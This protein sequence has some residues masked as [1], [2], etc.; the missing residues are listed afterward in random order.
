MKFILSAIGTST[1]VFLWASCAASERSRWPSRSVGHSVVP[2]L[3]GNA[4]FWPT[5]FPSVSSTKPLFPQSPSVR[6]LP[7]SIM[8][9][10]AQI[11]ISKWWHWF[12][13]HKLSYI[14][15]RNNERPRVALRNWNRYQ[16]IGFC[17]M[18]DSF[19]TY[20]REREKGIVHW[21]LECHPSLVH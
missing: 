17:K 2:L 15:V 1:S 11:N 10:S 9:K 21:T 16:T 18:F 3:Q 6:V 19:A 8:M 14:L 5:Y 12:P 13:I 20:K 4:F 7:I